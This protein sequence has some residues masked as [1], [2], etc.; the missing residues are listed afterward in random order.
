MEA[1][2]GVNGFEG[3]GVGGGD[4]DLGAAISFDITITDFAA[5][6]GHD[7]SAGWIGGVDEHGD[8]E[9]AGGEEFDDVR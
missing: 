8:V 2:E 1:Q 5:E 3:I 9:I 6:F 4:L 7:G